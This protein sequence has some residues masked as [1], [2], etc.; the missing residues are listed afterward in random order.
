MKRQDGFKMEN[1]NLKDIK[2][3][4]YSKGTK[5]INLNDIDKEEKNE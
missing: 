4:E 3:T 5:M 1:D 2:T